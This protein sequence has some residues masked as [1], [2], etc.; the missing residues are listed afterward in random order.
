[1]PLPP[2][3]EI[4]PNYGGCGTIIFLIG[5]VMILATI[6]GWGFSGCP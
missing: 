1:M 3:A 5:L 2:E 6:F 4:G